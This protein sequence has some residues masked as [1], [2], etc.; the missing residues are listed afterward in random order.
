MV[1]HYLVTHFMVCK[2][3]VFNF[4]CLHEFLKLL[5]LREDLETAEK[6]WNLE[7]KLTLHPGAQNEVIL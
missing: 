1:S 2:S 6:Q 7:T 3:V 4:T 5:N